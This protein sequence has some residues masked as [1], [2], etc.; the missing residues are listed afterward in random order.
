MPL[1]K[2]ALVWLTVL[3]ALALGTD[4][5]AAGPQPCTLIT[6]AEAAQIL[7]EAVKAPRQKVVTGMA[8]GKSCVYY[9][10]APLA[11]RGGVGSV[12]ITVYD[13]ETMQGGI[14]TS[15]EEFYQRLLRAGRKAKAPIQEISGLG[16]QAH[17]SVRGNSLHLL[18]KGVYVVLKVRDLKKMSAAS[19]SE[20]DKKVSAHY[21]QLAEAAARKYILPRL[22]ADQAPRPKAD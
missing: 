6:R 7:G 14:F 19:A 5:P 8:K 10:A 20:L 12:D 22:G 3:V 21:R 2:I 16:E 1:A 15:P 9:T 13:A 17:W 11:Q 18:S 4:A